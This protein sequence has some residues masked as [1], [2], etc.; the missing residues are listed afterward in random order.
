VAI[1][2]PAQLDLTGGAPKGTTTFTIKTGYDGPLAYAKRGLIASQVFSGTVKDDPTDSFNE[3]DPTKS[4]GFVPHDIVVPAGT[5]L[6]RINMYDAETD[7][8]D[9][10]DLYLYKV[11]ADGKLTE[12]GLSGSGTSAEQIQLLDPAAA[13][14]R[15]FVHGWETDGPDAVYKLHSWALGTTD[16]GNMTVTGPTA[17][18][19]GKTSTVT[20]NWT[21]LE[22][23]KK[24]LGQILYNEAAT[25]HG[26][27]IVR[28]DG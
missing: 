5:A 4:Q 15:L 17:A 26:S 8:A 23:G 7:G 12:V 16:A 24:Y 9:D 18:E 3:G 21:G 22:A 19:T 25:T 10:I 1:A 11:E 27:T 13:T 28:I 6:L 20:L 2:A 14:Y